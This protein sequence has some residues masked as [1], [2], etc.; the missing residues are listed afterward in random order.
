[1]LEALLEQAEG[2][3]GGSVVLAPRARSKIHQ[4]FAF[5]DAF[6]YMP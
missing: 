2:N 3:K 4:N 5:A 1:M 6:D